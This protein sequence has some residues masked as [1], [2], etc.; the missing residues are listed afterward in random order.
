MLPRLYIEI[1]LI[2]CYKFIQAGEFPALVRRVSRMIRGIG[3][4]LAAQYLR[5]FLCMRAREMIPHDY[6]EIMFET[7]HDFLFTFKKLKETQFK[8]ISHIQSEQVTVFEYLNLLAPATQ[9]LVQNV[10]WG[11]GED[12]FLATLQQFKDC[13]NNSATLEHVISAFKPQLVSAY[14][15]SMTQLIRESEESG[16]PK[17]RLY[18]ILGKALIQSAPPPEQRLQ[19][20]N[21]V[22]K[23]VTKLTDTT[24]Y[25]EI[26]QVFVEYL[27]Q[28]FATRE[29]N[30]LLA[31]VIKHVKKEQAYRGLQP[32]LQLVISKILQYRTNFDQL[33]AMDNFM[34]VLD[35]LEKEYKSTICKAVLESFAKN[36]KPTDD[37]VI[38]Q[39]VFEV[40]RGLHDSIDSLSFEDERRQVSFLIISFIRKIDF[41]HDLEQQ[42]NLYVECRAAFTNL[43]QVTRELVLRVALLCM[44][45]HRF[46]HGKHSKKTAAFVKACLAFCH[47]T[48]PS[49]DDI[50]LK[51][52]LLVEVA[53]VALVNQMTG[54]SEALLKAAISLVP[55]VPINIERDGKLVPTDNL[56]VGF[57]NSFASMLLL[58]PG[59]PEHGPF[60]LVKGLLNVVKGYKPWYVDIIT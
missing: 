46:V 11:S 47:I 52:H 59:H 16:T 40:A 24:E 45:A 55:D 18:F 12:I 39:T 50:F 9:W 51:L 22:W 38:I 29:T 17:S 57:L 14:A 4:P 21:E 32:Q 31:D 42:L 35:L 13:S 6:K 58:F 48:I 2:R 60:H 28:H 10:A 5:A 33:L 23:V 41:G 37:P 27:L 26:T 53:Q 20:L 7:F 36:Q 3:D 19:I 30:I 54:Q 25:M 15:T 44:R 8:T 43:D 1:A 49:L 56:L 34:P